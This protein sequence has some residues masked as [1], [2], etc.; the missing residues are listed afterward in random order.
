MYQNVNYTTNKPVVSFFGQ[1]PKIKE[2]FTGIDQTVGFYD[3][4]GKWVRSLEK[5]PLLHKMMSQINYL[6]RF[7]EKKKLVEWS[8]LEQYVLGMLVVYYKNNYAFN[9][10][11]A[12]AYYRMMRSEGVLPDD[13]Y[14]QEVVDNF[15]TTLNPFGSS[16][17]ERI[18]GIVVK[19]HDDPVIAKFFEAKNVVGPQGDPVA[20][21]G[22]PYFPGYEPKEFPWV[23]VL[24][25]SVVVGGYLFVKFGKKKRKRK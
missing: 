5:F 3:E 22:D 19:Y 4:N 24:I 25:G 20:P 23:P 9:T 14:F 15:N 11:N 21:A 2:W 16:E 18:Y 6:L 1:Y 8:R 17:F 13:G 7:K 10:W 12:T